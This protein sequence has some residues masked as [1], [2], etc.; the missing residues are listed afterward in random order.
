LTSTEPLPMP[1]KLSIPV[2]KT[3]YVSKLAKDYLSGNN[4]GGLNPGIPNLEQLQAKANERVFAQESRTVLVEALLNQYKNDGVSLSEDSEVL[5]NI[6]SLLLPNTFSVTTG[7]QIHIFLGPLFFVYKIQSLLALAKRFNSNTS[8]QTVVPVFW[9]ASEDHD[10]AE[11][12]YVKLYGETYSWEPTAGNAVGR[13]TCDGLPEIINRLEARA[14][15]NAENE[16]LYALFRK[17]YVDGKKLSAATRSLLHELFEDQGLIIIDP[18]DSSLKKQFLPAIKQ[19]IEDKILFNSGKEQTKILKQNGYEPR[20]NAQEINFF[21]LD[22]NQRVKLKVKNNQIFKDNT[23]VEISKEEIYATPEKISPNVLTR[24]LYQETILPNILYLGGSAEIEYWLPLQEAFKQ[25]GLQYPLLMQRDSMLIL[26]SKNLE[27]I[28]KN[29]FVWNELFQSEQ[30]IAKVFFAKHEHESGKI[31]SLIAGMQNHLDELK[32]D[33]EKKET[34]GIVHR[35]VNELQKG[36]A[37]LARIISEEELKVQKENV[38]VSKLLKL[39]VKFFDSKQER[40]EFVISYPFVLQQQFSKTEDI[41]PELI[42]KIR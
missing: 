24:P 16:A 21:W 29:G 37:K 19:E 20:V 22:D 9:M 26:S 41:Q 6:Q 40:D 27:A 23:E 36:I 32:T 1:D 10:L 30:E 38:T 25:L 35:E 4:L 33:L 8:S 5:K 11:I 34:P 14:D 12:N 39:K 2:I 42:L 7:Q 28:E 13:I 31:T 18:D 15:K 17:H 3:P